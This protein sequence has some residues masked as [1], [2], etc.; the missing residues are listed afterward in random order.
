MNQ[1]T[2][3]VGGVLAAILLAP[4]IASADFVLDTGVPTGTGAAVLLNSSQWVAGEFTATAGQ[5]ITSVAAYLTQGSGQPGDT[6]TFDI[7]ANAGFTGRS[8]ARQLVTPAITATFTANGWNTAA[9]DWTPTTSGEYWLALQ[10]SSSTMTRG[11]DVPTE[12]SA[13]TGTVPALGFAVAG[14]NGQFANSASGFGLQVSAVPLPAAV[15]LFGSGILGLGAL[16]RR[17]RAAA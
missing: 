16:A 3:L 1:K 11:L 8:N 9:V 12:T 4:G 10:V 14:Q 13:Q 15:W 5:T 2:T 6:F 17:R 7:Y